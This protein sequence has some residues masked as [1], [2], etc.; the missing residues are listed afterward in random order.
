MLRSHSGPGNE[1]LQNEADRPILDFKFVYLLVAK[2][3]QQK[4]K[5]KSIF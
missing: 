5:T 1:S 3:T 2:P 4:P